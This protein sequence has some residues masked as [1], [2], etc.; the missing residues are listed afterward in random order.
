[1][2]QEK[3]TDLPNFL[4]IVSNAKKNDVILFRGQSSNKGLLPSIAR[5]DPSADTTAVEKEM[6]T[7]LRR[8]GDMVF[9][10]SKMDDWDLMVLAQHF[11]MSTRLLDWTSNPLVALWFACSFAKE[12]QNSFVYAFTVKDEYLLD[13]TK[14]KDPFRK[15][16]TRVFK[17]K[18]NNNRIVAQSGWFT[19]HKYSYTN[20][21]FV[22]LNINSELTGSITRIEIPHEQHLS[23]RT[24]LNILGI[25]NQTMF[26]DMAGLCKHINWLHE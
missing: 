2:K 6:L 3:F 19:A 15:T 26:P 17:P 1:M 9:E 8:R 7:E 18:L 22:P 21:K 25:N 4:G 16:R 11:G 14:D 13:R 24:Q 10:V 23:L 12:K 20:N 5:S